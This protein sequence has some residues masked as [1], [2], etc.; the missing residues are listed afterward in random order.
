MKRMISILLVF[1]LAVSGLTVS[2][3][4]G[5]A[6]D[7]IAPEVRKLIADN[8]GGGMVVRIHYHNDNYP[9]EGLSEQESVTNTLAAQRELRESIEAITYCEPSNLIY[10]DGTMLMGLPYGSIE[11]VAALPNVDEIDLP[12]EGCYAPA[13]QKLSDTS[14]EKLAALNSDSEVNLVIW[15]AYNTNAYIGMAEPDDDCT[16]EEVNEY[17]HIMR[18]AKRN[19]VTAKNEEYVKRITDAVEVD[20]ITALTSAP[21]VFIR[22]TADKVPEIAALP[23]VWTVDIEEGTEPLDPPFEPIEDDPDTIDAKFEQWMW[24]NGQAVKQTDPDASVHYGEE[25]DYRDYQELYVGDDWA[26]IQAHWC[27]IELPWEMRFSIAFG[28]RILTEWTAGVTRFGYGLFVYD[29]SQDT[30]YPIEEVCPDAYAGILDVMEEL[31][32]GRPLGDA[33]GDGEINIVDATAIQRDLADLDSLPENDWYCMSNGSGWAYYL[34]AD[35]DCD[36]DVTV[37][38]AT[39]IQRRIAELEE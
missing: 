12:E 18:Q 5:S 19:Y 36:S 11:A 39:R 16:L 13:E 25:F 28:N 27:G 4:A 1:V 34:F 3:A 38:D 10:Y 33:D 32:I 29:K 37:M 35:A 17:L 9:A 22:T 21:M 23:E 20:S 6:D 2:A 26:M 7:K 14:K 8:A 30:F 31:H 24:V 15:L